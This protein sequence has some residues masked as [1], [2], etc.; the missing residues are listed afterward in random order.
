M[1]E[2]LFN[3]ATISIV[4]GGESRWSQDC[5]RKIAQVLRHLLNDSERFYVVV[6]YTVDI[7]IMFC[8]GP[9]YPLIASSIDE[10]FDNY[11]LYTND[12]YQHHDEM[13]DVVC[14]DS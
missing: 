12:R 11:K 9:M 4:E 8:P 2:K 10:Y 13:L 14:R 1:A 6:V 5:Y 3:N 7:C